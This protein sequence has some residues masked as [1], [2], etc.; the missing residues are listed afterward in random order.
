VTRIRAVGRVTEM[1][2]VGPF[3]VGLSRERVLVALGERLRVSC[4]SYDLDEI[5]FLAGSGRHRRFRVSNFA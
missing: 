1:G 5:Q 4:A 2:R 3:C